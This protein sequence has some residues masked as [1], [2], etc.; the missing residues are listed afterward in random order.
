MTTDFYPWK[1]G[2][3]ESPGENSH[4]G[5]KLPRV[6]QFIFC[7]S[8]FF[9]KSLLNLLQYCSYVFMFW[10]SGHEAYRI[11]VPQ[12]E[13][14]PTLPALEG[15]V[16]TGEVRGLAGSFEILILITMAS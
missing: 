7:P 1:L 13:T 6:A 16:L 15:K 11:L 8:S 14:E 10:V 3:P 2:D 5:G 12:A 9:K 4:L